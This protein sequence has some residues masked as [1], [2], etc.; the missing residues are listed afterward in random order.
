MNMNKEDK[1]IFIEQVMARPSCNRE[2]LLP[3]VIKRFECKVGAEIGVSWGNH[4]IHLLNSTNIYLYLVDNYRD[5]EPGRHGLTGDRR[6]RDAQKNLN[7]YIDGKRCELIKANSFEASL[8]IPDNSLD[9]LY[10]DADHSYEGTKTDINA[11]YPKVRVGGVVAG[12]DYK[13][14]AYCRVKKYIDEFIK[15]QGLR[16]F[17]IQGRGCG[18]IVIKI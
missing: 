12:H 9:F 14:R 6:Y 3:A 5:N 4:A 18:W 11:W 7:E 10:I 2:V 8:L 13:N 1:H 16:L 17:V 15:E